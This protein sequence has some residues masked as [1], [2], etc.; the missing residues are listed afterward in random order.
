MKST[1]IQR[2]FKGLI[3]NVILIGFSITCIYP[4]IWLFYS[5]FKTKQEFNNNPIALPQEITLE[6]FQFILGK[7]QRLLTWMKNSFFNTII[8]LFFILLIGF[9]VGYFIARVEFRGKK[10]VYTYFM[11][12]ILVPI[13]AL[14]IPLYV[15]FA[16]LGITNQWFTL[17][18]PYTAF[19]LPIVIFLVD[20]YVKSIPRDIEEAAS[21]DGSSFLRT[22]FSIIFPMCVPILTTGGIIQFFSCWN[23]FSFALILVDDQNLMTIPVGMTLLKGQYTTDYPRM[24]CSMFIAILP[25][26]LIYFIFSKQIIKGMVAGAVKG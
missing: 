8:S 15:L 2:F 26:A 14:M 17:V 11:F 12:G 13:H 19:G 16:K 6:N 21:I 23:E 1:G 24:M 5:S 25:A 18:L 3:P 20:S 22:L 4:L 10:A 9:I 7:G